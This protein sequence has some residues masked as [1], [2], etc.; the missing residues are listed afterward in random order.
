MTKVI[1]HSCAEGCARKP[2]AA[3]IDRGERP[4][5]R[6]L[7]VQEPAVGELGAS[8]QRKPCSSARVQ[9]HQLHSE[10]GSLLFPRVTWTGA[11]DPIFS[12]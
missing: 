11:C 9:P 6:A 5:E 10:P 7:K 2:A 3:E 8:L 12:L 1:K 4:L